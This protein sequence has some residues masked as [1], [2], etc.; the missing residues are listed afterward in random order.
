M[1]TSGQTADPI[2]PNQKSVNY[3]N[4][5]AEIEKPFY[6]VRVQRG[7]L[8]FPKN[9]VQFRRYREKKFFW[10]DCIIFLLPTIFVVAKV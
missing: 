1:L 6:C 9:G 7:T 2:T 5:S 4:I 3:V 8:T 10:H